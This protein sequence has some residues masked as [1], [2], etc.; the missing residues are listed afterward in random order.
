MERVGIFDLDWDIEAAI[1]DVKVEFTPI[2]VEEIAPENMNNTSVCP[3]EADFRIGYDG[4]PSIFKDVESCSESIQGPKQKFG[5]ISTEC[6][7][8]GFVSATKSCYWSHK[9]THLV[10]KA[11]KCKYCTKSFAKKES[12]VV[13]TYIHTGEYAY[14][15][16]FCNKQF[17][18]NWGRKLHI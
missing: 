4:D 5:R 12:L 8:C 13:H 18:S 1:T 10:D 17:R 15:C 11:Y 3:N 7:V 6:E 14:K 2:I 9:Q 16:D